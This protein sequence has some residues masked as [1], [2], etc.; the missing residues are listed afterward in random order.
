MKQPT[1]FTID[2]QLSDV[3]RHVLSGSGGGQAVESGSDAVA[4]A[5]LRWEIPKDPS[6][7]DLS[8]AVS[9]KLASRRHQSP[10]H[11]AE[12]LSQAF[13]ARC[14]GDGLGDWIERVEAKAGF[15]NVFLSPRALTQV[16]RSI[17]GQRHRYGT[18]RTHSATS[19]NIEF[20][21]ANPTGPL[22]VAHGR[23]AAVGD[24]LARLLRS[25]GSLVTSEYYLNDEGRQIELLGKSLRA[26]CL[27]ALGQPE[28]FPEDGYQGAYVIASA[29]RLHKTYGEALR[30]KPLEWF[31][32]K[33]MEEQLADIKRDLEQF[34]L[35]F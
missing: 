13:F 20:V 21:S 35:R 16:L 30:D 28:P 8:N 11:V 15:L 31:M 18:R 1:V 33:G 26:R 10:Q 6:F 17:L 4:E 19:V 7:G 14:R 5:A 12:E 2:D 27:E 34:G 25:Q 32:Q 3:L 22:S 24:V 23:Q 29:G 9:F